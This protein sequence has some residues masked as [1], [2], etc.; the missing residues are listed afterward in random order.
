MHYE[1]LD[2]WVAVDSRDAQDFVKDTLKGWYGSYVN[3]EEAVR[4]SELSASR[5]P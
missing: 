2:A 3:A 5:S 1:L 4:T